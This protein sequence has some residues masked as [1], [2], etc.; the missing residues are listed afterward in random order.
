MVIGQNWEQDVRGAV[1]SS[2]GG[3]MLDEALI[4]RIKNQIR[5]QGHFRHVPAKVLQVARYSTHRRAARSWSWRCGRWCMEK[6]R[7]PKAWPTRRRWSS[8]VIYRN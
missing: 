2:A 6:V 5:Q 4:D 3:L 7:T 8:T 1:R